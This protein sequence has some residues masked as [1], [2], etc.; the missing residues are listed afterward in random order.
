MP[1][2]EAETGARRFVAGSL[3]GLTSALF[4]Y[5]LELIRIRLAFETYH[6]PTQHSSLMRTIRSIY[7]D[8]PSSRPGRERPPRPRQPTPSIKHFYRGIVPSLFGI[9][10]YAGVSFFTWGF[11]KQEVFPAYFSDSFRRRNRTML[12]LVAGGLAGALGQT[13]AYPLDI[14]RRRMQVGPAVEPGS[15]KG[16]WQTASSVYRQSGWRGFFLGLSIGFLKVVPMNAVSFT[17]SLFATPNP[18]HTAL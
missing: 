1:T 17:V 16:F 9:V 8:S 3:A 12:D 14:V 18:S 6:S 10:P 2:R 7:H 15:R 13:A 5:P 11:I 4:T